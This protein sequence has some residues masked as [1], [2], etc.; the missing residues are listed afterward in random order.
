MWWLLWLVFPIKTVMWLGGSFFTDIL[1]TGSTK[2]SENIHLLT[3]LI[4]SRGWYLQDHL[5]LRNRTLSNS[6]VTVLVY[7]LC[8]CIL[9]FNLWI[10]WILWI[11]CYGHCGFCWSCGL[12]GFCRCCSYCGFF[13]SVDAVIIVDSVDVVGAVDLLIFWLLWIQW[14]TWFL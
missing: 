8:Y 14:V 9:I 1:E 3:V 12:R 10:M 5:A 13:G 6:S 11:C 7:W 4:T 2:M